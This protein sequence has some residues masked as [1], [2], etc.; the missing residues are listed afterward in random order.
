MFKKT[1]EK[2]FIGIAVL[3]LSGGLFMQSYQIINPDFRYDSKGPFV[4]K[5]I[6]F[7]NNPVYDNCFMI[8]GA[9]S[10]I[11]ALY[12]RERRLRKEFM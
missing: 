12:L 5:V 6:D 8:A 9:G 1:L 2:V 3:G 10:L 7:C 11:T 4:K